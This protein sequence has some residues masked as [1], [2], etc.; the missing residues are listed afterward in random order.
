MTTKM[1][2]LLLLT[3]IILI[4]DDE[5]SAPVSHSEIH[6]AATVFM[7][8]V[9][10]GWGELHTEANWRSTATFGACMFLWSRTL[11]YDRKARR[12]QA[13]SQSL[14][15]N[16]YASQ[17]DEYWEQML[18]R[19][20]WALSALFYTAVDAYVGAHLHNFEQDRVP[21]P[22]NWEPGELP[23]PIEL[24]ETVDPGVVLAQWQIK[25]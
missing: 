24:S 13:Y 18:D 10:P 14:N 6:T 17:V 9:F 7:T 20:W 15:G 1:I 12:L 4:A 25:F 23:Q 5:P 8:P 19:G 2:L 16:P 22:D 11:M 21:V 3:P